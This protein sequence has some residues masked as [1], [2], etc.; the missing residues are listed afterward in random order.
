MG[1]QTAG[2]TVLNKTFINNV[3]LELLCSDFLIKEMKKEKL[4][5]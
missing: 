4:R 3:F 5:Y 1:V 2:Y